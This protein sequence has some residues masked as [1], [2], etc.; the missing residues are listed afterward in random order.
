MHS[1]ELYEKRN[2]F[3]FHVT[4]FPFLPGNITSSPS[5]GISVSD[6]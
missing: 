2:K 3:A 5:H 1:T 6:S 4:N